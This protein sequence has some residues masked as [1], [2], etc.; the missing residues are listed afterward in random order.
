QGL[1][2]RHLAYVIYTSGSTGT[3]KGVAIEHANTL[4]LLAWAQASF[5]AAELSHTL[6]AT[7]TNFDLAVF[8]LFVPLSCGATVSL[9]PDVLAVTAQDTMTLINTVP[10]GIDA[11]LRSQCVPDTVRTIN[12][13]GE[14]LKPALVAQLFA[15]TSAEEVVNLYGPSETTTY[16]TWVRMDRSHAGPVLIGRPIANTQVYILDAQGEPVP[17]GVAGEL[18]IGGDGV[19]R[20]YLN[21]PALT[22]ERFVRDPFSAA[23][24]ARMYKTGDLGRWLPDGNIEYLGRNDFQVKIRGF[25]IELGEI[26]AR[27]AGCAGVRE[28]VVLAREDEPGDK[29]LVA[30]LTADTGADLSVAEL[31]TRLSAQLPDYMVPSAFVVLD[32]FPLTPNGKLDRKALPA[33]D[34]TSLMRREYEAPQG[35]IEQE[36]AEVWQSLLNIEQVGRHDHFFE[37]GGHSLLVVAMTTRLRAKGLRGEV[38][39]SLL[40]AR[41]AFAAGGRDDHAS[42]REGLARRSAP[43]ICR[44]GIERLRRHLASWRSGR[45]GGRAAQPVDAGAAVD[46]ARAAAAGQ[47]DAGRNR[48]RCRNRARWRRQ[49]P[50]HLPAAA[51]PARHP[52]SSH[53]GRRGRHL[54]VAGAAGV[55]SPRGT[56]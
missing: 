22:A 46:I 39:R 30:Y 33:P 42:A 38:P 6:F 8:E 2:S 18:Y 11:L 29:R 40:R 23:P 41:R 16:S 1:S 34:A 17:V 20:G 10:S 7:S 5:T 19:A 32:A 3:P 37:L 4:N 56:R 49:R 53:A 9:R 52:V 35:E 26:E 15:G 24:Q 43:P 51:V 21:Q 47:P 27:L 13:A 28:A 54:P 45:G 48:L 36:L 50:G 14:A 25:R 12:L 31:R 55:R 44:A